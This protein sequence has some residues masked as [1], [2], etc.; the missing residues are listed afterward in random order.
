MVAFYEHLPDPYSSLTITTET[1]KGGLLRDANFL[2]LLYSLCDTSKAWTEQRIFVF[3]H[4]TVSPVRS[5]TSL[6]VR[7]WDEEL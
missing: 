2:L 3:V 1:L 6:R 4:R 5:A 7:H